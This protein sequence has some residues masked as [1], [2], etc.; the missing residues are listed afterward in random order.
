MS[1]G[2]A[3]PGKFRKRPVVI[4][5]VQLGTRRYINTREGTLTGEPGDWLITGVEGEQYP[6]ANGIFLKTYEPVDDLA[7][8]LW[9]AAMEQFIAELTG[10]Q[11]DIRAALECERGPRS[12]RRAPT[13]SLSAYLELQASQRYHG[14]DI[15]GPRLSYAATWAAR[16]EDQI[17][18]LQVALNK[19]T[20]QVGAGADLSNDNGYLTPRPPLPGTSQT[21]RGGAGEGEDGDGSNG[22]GGGKWEDG[23]M[24]TGLRALAQGAGLETVLEALVQ[25]LY[26]NPDCPRDCDLCEEM[27]CP[28]PWGYG[29]DV[30]PAECSS[31]RAH[32]I[33]W[34]RLSIAK[35]MDGTATGNGTAGGVQAPALQRHDD[36][37]AGGE[38]QA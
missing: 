20:A 29:A 10:T 21:A 15:S 26:G 2:S 3:T 36:G 27:G 7:L 30:P 11:V 8:A 6:C 14:D 35:T 37:A 18:A 24:E 22:D 19:A 23:Y 1:E 32:A 31:N 28:W 34:A 13:T 12:V 4:E 9:I 16:L 33:C 5:A 25:E 38:G 17:D